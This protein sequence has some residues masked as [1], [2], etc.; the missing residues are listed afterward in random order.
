MTRDSIGSGADSHGYWPDGGYFGVEADVYC[1]GA[2]Q[3]WTG[4]V[5][6]DNGATGG[7]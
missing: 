1:T 5:W 3:T 4:N 7:C 6:D 2:G